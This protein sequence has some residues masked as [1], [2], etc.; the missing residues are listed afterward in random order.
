MT[1]RALGHQA[2]VGL[3][4]RARELERGLRTTRGRAC[5]PRCR[6]LWDLRQTGG[7]RGLA[8]DRRVRPLHSIQEERCHG[9]GGPRRW[10]VRRPHTVV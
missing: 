9:G 4:A 6:G 2:E 1:A 3:A 7:I 8:L 10:A 5:R